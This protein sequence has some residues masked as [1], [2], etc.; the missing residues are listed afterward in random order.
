L[1]IRQ[2]QLDLPCSLY[3][4]LGL[5]RR[6][7]VQ[8]KFPHPLLFFVMALPTIRAEPLISSMGAGGP[9][10]SQTDESRLDTK[11]ESGHSNGRPYHFPSVSQDHRIRKVFGLSEDA[12]LPVVTDSALAAYHAYL[13]ENLSLPFEA[14]FCPSGSEMRQLIQY[15]QVTELSDPGHDGSRHRRGLFCKAHNVKEIVELPLD[16][17]GVRDE[18]PNSQLIDDYAYW[19]VNCR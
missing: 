5:L 2:A 15:V 10:M 11:T 3:K 7:E 19:F 12:P 8:E 14:L 6:F 18:N 13:V 16:E 1:S 17:L 4:R 9:L